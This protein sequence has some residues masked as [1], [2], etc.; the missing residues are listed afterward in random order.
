MKMRTLVFYR[1]NG[2]RKVSYCILT[3]PIRTA[4]TVRIFH[5]HHWIEVF[6][7]R[8]KGVFKRADDKLRNPQG[9]RSCSNSCTAPAC[10]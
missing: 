10:G 7:K 1:G 5:Q 6:W 3:Q 9:A 8:C 4:E 2:H